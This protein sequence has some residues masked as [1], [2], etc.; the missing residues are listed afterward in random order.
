MADAMTADSSASIPERVFTPVIA[1]DRINSIDVLRGVALLGILIVNIDLF[2]LPTAVLM[3]P[4]VAGGFSGIHLLTWKFQFMGFYQKMMSIFSMLFGAGLVLMF[5]RAEQAGKKLGGVYYRRILWLGILGLLHA[6][7]LWFGDI[8]FFYAFCGLLL[9]LF[10]RKSP[11][12]LII[13]GS[14]T[15]LVGVVL[16]AGIG[17]MNHQLR[18]RAEAVADAR[19]SGEEV[20]DEDEAI[21]RTW[22]Q[23][24]SMLYPPEE[25]IQRDIDVHRG[26]YSGIFIARIPQVITMHTQAMIFMIFWRVMGLMLIGMGLL[27][28]GV[29]S[30]TCPQKVYTWFIIIGYGVG[31]PL[32]YIG[33]E[34]LIAHDFDLIRQLRLDMHYNY[35]GSMF[36]AFG[37]IGVV[38]TVCKANVLNGQTSRL[39][40]VGRMALTNYLFHTIVFT[41]LFYG[42]GVGLFGTIDRFWLAGMAIAMW[43]LQ[44]IVSPIWLKHFRFGPAE[45]LWRTLTYWKRQP[46]RVEKVMEANVASRLRS[47]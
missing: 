43:I 32:V 47:M 33:M 46:I 3:D 28:L 37:H 2:A 24:R 36:V 23:V 10:R 8:L 38:M 12:T 17:E 19:A 42:Y 45:W 30:A 39:A 21:E 27:K 16:M 31:L 14:I 40:A 41:T 18:T 1:A 22:E 9:F 35:I 25:A 26:D 15:L 13:V 4:P 20:T 7:L 34:Q 29:L 6:Y 44:L 11:K 5:S